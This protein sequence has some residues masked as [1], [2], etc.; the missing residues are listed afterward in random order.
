MAEL[1]PTDQVIIAQMSGDI[2]TLL[3]LDDA[4]TAAV[5]EV[6]AEQAY[7]GHPPDPASPRITAAR[8]LG[9]ELAERLEQ[10]G[11]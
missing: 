7:L 5:Q 10:I 4:W 11:R 3:L 9:G 6:N 1:S 8:R 2:T